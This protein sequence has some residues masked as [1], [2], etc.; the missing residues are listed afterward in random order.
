MD[1]SYNSSYYISSNSTCSLFFF[2]SKFLSSC[3]ID[4][5]TLTYS[6]LSLS[7][8]ISYYIESRS[9]LSISIDLCTGICSKCLISISIKSASYFSSNALN[10]YFSSTNY[11]LLTFTFSNSSLSFL[12]N[13]LSLS[14]SLL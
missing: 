2:F 5:N 10:F 9:S 6:L 12:V 3:L 14:D 11:S 4:C 8:I 1:Y 13:D 7:V